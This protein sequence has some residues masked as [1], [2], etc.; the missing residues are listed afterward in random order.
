M[1]VL[2]SNLSNQESLLK[3][4]TFERRDHTLFL[5]QIKNEFFSGS[6]A[7]TAFFGLMWPAAYGS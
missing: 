7:A 2:L 1:I 6:F 3:Q 5:L 4:V